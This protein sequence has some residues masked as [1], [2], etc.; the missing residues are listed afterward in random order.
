L[1]YSAYLGC[2]PNRVEV[3]LKYHNSCFLLA[4]KLKGFLFTI[5]IHNQ[6]K[7]N[8][9]IQTAN[10]NPKVG[11]DAPIEAPKQITVEWANG[12]T[13]TLGLPNITEAE[14]V[15][16]NPYDKTIRLIAACLISVFR[17][18]KNHTYEMLTLGQKMVIVRSWSYAQMEAVTRAMPKFLANQYLNIP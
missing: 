4:G 8:M 18:G 15:A 17:D 16:L 2:Y 10:Q 12:N 5:L 7:F 9:K 14:N 3:L 13:C 1:A 6:I 11:A